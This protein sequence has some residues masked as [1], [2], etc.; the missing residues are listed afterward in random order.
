LISEEEEHPCEFVLGNLSGDYFKDIVFIGGQP[1]E[2][3]LSHLCNCVLR[4]LVWHQGNVLTR[5]QIAQN[6]GRHNSKSVKSVAMSI[7]RLR[8]VLTK[9]GWD[10]EIRNIVGF[11]YTIPR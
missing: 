1:L 4:V 7:G 9:A 8:A 10:G 2:P 5:E 11:G 3:T 6:V